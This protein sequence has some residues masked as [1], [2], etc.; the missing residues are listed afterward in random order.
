M[1]PGQSSG[2]YKKHVD[3]VLPASNVELCLLEVPQHRYGRRVRRQI[4]CAPVHELLAKEAELH[5]PEATDMEVNDWSSGFETHPW[6]HIPGDDRPV[7][8]IALYLDGIRYTRATL[9]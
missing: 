4:A 1:K 9:T 7:W 8:P 5:P 2:N 6:R 3:N